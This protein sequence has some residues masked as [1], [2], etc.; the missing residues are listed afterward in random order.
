MST[1]QRFEPDDDLDL[2][3]ALFGDHE[4]FLCERHVQDHEKH[5]HVPVNDYLRAEQPDM[6]LPEIPGITITVVMCGNCIVESEQGYE[7]EAHEIEV[8]DTL[9]E[10]W[11]A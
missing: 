11:S 9:P 4:C 10:E 7:A 1:E 2:G 8:P 5:I 3:A 6:V